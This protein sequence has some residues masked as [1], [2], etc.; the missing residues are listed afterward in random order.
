MASISKYD[1]D[2]SK[3]GHGI[4]EVT[5]TSPKTSKGWTA[6]ITDMELIDNT[7]NEES[8]LIKHLN[9]LKRSVKLYSK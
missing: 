5:F 2:F 6:R 8:P 3:V 9:E 7:K 4:Y 1:F